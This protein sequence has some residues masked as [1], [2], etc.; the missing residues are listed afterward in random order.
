M[1][2]C[3]SCTNL[4][5]QSSISGSPKRK[6]KKKKGVRRGKGERNQIVGF[7]AER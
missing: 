3:P 7:E 2:L 1:P 5:N 6:K 4:G